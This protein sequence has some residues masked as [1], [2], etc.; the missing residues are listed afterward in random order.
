MKAQELIK[1]LEP[2]KGA[3]QIVIDNL[4][5]I[6]ISPK[7]TM[8]VVNAAIQAFSGEG[9]DSRGNLYADYEEMLTILDWLGYTREKYGLVR[10]SGLIHYKLRA[11]AECDIDSFIEEYPYMIALASRSNDELSLDW[12]FEFSSK[13]SLNAIK[14]AIRGLDD[15]HVMEQ[16]VQSI[17]LYTG[18][19]V[20]D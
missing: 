5:V 14:A 4:F 12:E 18:E 20:I 8:R 15:C 9:V 3:L 11:E 1:T 13:Y 2:H 17:G 10:R 16:T 6:T 7:N 19:R